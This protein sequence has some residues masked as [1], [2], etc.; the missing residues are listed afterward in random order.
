[1]TTKQKRALEFLQRHHARGAYLK[2]YGWASQDMLRNDPALA[3]RFHKQI[4][5]LKHN[6]P[7]IH[8]ANF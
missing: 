6:A 5:R 7:L 4:V 8:L 2:H 1:M 3:K